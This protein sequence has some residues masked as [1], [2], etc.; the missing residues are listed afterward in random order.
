MDNKLDSVTRAVTANGGKSLPRHVGMIYSLNVP[1]RVNYCCSKQT[2]LARLSA[3]SLDTTMEEP[4]SPC[5]I[6]IDEAI[7]GCP[8]LSGGR[9]IS[10]LDHEV[11]LDVVEK[12]AV[13]VPV[14]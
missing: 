5:L 14:W 9:G 13:V 4:P 6:A 1:A 10:R 11:L 3:K 7:Q 12:A 8:A 2:S